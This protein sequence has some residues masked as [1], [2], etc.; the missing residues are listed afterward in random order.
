MV[1]YVFLSFFL[2]VLGIAAVITVTAVMLRRARRERELA[3]RK[4]KL[5]SEHELD[6]FIRQVDQAESDEDLNRLDNE[7]KDRG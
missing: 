5:S 3:R 7:R 4:R 1:S 6:A 2:A